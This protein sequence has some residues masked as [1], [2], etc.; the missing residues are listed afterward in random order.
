MW[1]AK[2]HQRDAEAEAGAV[3]MQHVKIKPQHMSVCAKQ[4]IMATERYAI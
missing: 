1:N 2:D 4:V 3:C